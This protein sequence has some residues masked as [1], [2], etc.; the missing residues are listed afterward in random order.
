MLQLPVKQKNR[1]DN[2]N[3]VR[4]SIAAQILD[5]VF[6]TRC[7]GCRTWSETLF[8]PQC[9]LRLNP[10]APPLCACCGVSFDALAHVLSD[11]LCADCRENRYHRAP[12]LDLRR[13]PFRYSGPIRKAIHLFKYRGKTALAKPIAALLREYSLNNDSTGFSWEDIEIIVPV[14]LHGVRKWRRGYNQSALLAQ[15]LGK[16]AQIPDAEILRR[17]RHTTPQVE[18]EADERAQNVKDAFTINERAWREYSLCKSVLLIDDVSTTGAT[19][20]ECARVLKKHGAEKV[21]A[22][23]LAR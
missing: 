21:C 5:I 11:S 17:T 6:P 19:L 14:P 7:A 10:V 22:L 1:R 8:C 12:I 9:A 13:A 16:L 3:R 15:E 20:E 23:T 18:L 4:E 2:A